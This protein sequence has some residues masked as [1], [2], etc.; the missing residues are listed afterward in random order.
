MWR[1]YGCG[2]DTWVGMAV[3]GTAMAIVLGVAWLIRR[4]AEWCA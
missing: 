1:W 2:R 4:L 3:F